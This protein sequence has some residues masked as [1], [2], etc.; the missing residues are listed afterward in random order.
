MEEWI[1]RLRAGEPLNREQ[2][3]MLIG[4]ADGDPLLFQQAVQVRQA[5]YGR[6]I[7]IRGL[8]ELTNY[9]KNDCRY[10]GIRR[11][12]R[13]AQRYRLSQ[14]QVL[15]CCET[16]Y[17]LGFRTFVLQGGEDPAATDGFLCGLIREIKAAWP[18]CA[19]TLSMGERSR[20]SYQALREAGADRYLLRH[21]T[22]CP[23]HYQQLHPADLQLENRIRCLEDLADLGYQTGS[24]FMVGS[25]GQTVD[26]LAQDML[27][28]TR[29]RPQMVGIGP[30]LPHHDTPFAH[31]PPGR[32][33]L[34]L[35]MVALTRLLLPQALIPATTALATLDP[36]GRELGILAGANVVMPNLSPPDVR[37]KYLLY[38]NK[39]HSGPESAEAVADLK[40][41]MERIGYH[42]VTDRGDWKPPQS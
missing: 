25:P 12:N 21:E 42:V 10:C 26:C 41:S 30:F 28:L 24:G 40:A 3:A 16:G 8:I 35:R 9:C 14:D 4:N 15:A 20:A 7:Y 29:L 17:A 19:V 23:Q 11:S 34:T 13:Q 1:H 38:D 6:D 5:V 33:D 37:E 22:A 2:W 18:D 31:Y 27:L 36:Q 32:L 39:A